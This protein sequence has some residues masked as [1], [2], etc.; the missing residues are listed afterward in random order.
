[1]IIFVFFYQPFLIVVIGKRLAIVKR[2][3]FFGSTGILPDNRAVDVMVPD[4]I[5]TSRVC[6]L[7]HQR[8]QLVWSEIVEII[9]SDGILGYELNEAVHDLIIPSDA[10]RCCILHAM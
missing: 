7:D 3:V 1:M 6:L 2:V 9:G 10:P 8:L 5:E 4:S